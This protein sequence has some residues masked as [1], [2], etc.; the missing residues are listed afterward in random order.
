MRALF[1]PS[2]KPLTLFFQ[3]CD[4]NVKRFIAPRAQGT[5]MC[6]QRSMLSQSASFQLRSL[7]GVMA[8][9]LAPKVMKLSERLYGFVRRKSIFGPEYFLN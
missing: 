7:S 9:D 3:R 1:G 5:E 4:N 2:R 8:R 6:G